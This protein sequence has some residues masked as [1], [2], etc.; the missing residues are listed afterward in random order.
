[1][2]RK[3]KPQPVSNVDI[4]FEQDNGE[5]EEIEDSGIHHEFDKTFMKAYTTILQMILDRGYIGEG[6]PGIVSTEEKE[7]VK[8]TLETKGQLIEKY[9]G[10]ERFSLSLYHQN[11]DFNMLV[12]YIIP[13]VGESSS[14]ERKQINEAQIRA[15]LANFS[16]T[17]FSRLLLISRTKLSSQAAALVATA[18]TIVVPGK[19]HNMVQFLPLSFF[20]FNRTHNI[21]QPTD[22][23]IYR[24]EIDPNNPEGQKIVPLLNDLE[25]P[26]EF[27]RAKSAVLPQLYDTDPIALYYGLK[28]DDV[29]SYIRKFPRPI[30]FY[31]VVV[32]SY[33]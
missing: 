10:L 13:L 31:R 1:M 8:V 29:I 27:T 6:I 33:D 22:L 19:P 28:V 3:N 9:R 15:I 5:E 26:V 2:S 23:Q 4:E 21:D 32:R 11:P 17:D 25:V 20:M 14:T 7:E 18:N 30:R 16:E 12:Y 24:P